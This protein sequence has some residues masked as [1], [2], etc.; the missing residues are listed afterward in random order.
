MS[1]RALTILCVL[2][3]PFFSG[4]EAYAAAR[5]GLKESIGRFTALER[6]SSTTERDE[7]AVRKNLLIAAADCSVSEAEAARETLKAFPASEMGF[8]PASE[9]L[10]ERLLETIAYAAE[11]KSRVNDVGIRGTK[12]I[13]RALKE[14]R[15]NVYLPAA[16]NVANLDLWK[17]TG[18]LVTVAERR[19]RQ[20]D[21]TLETLNLDDRRELAGYRD[22][23]GRQ[24]AS[25]KSALATARMK[26]Q[27]LDR[28]EEISVSIRIALD[29]LSKAYSQFFKISEEVN[30]VVPIGG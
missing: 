25:A 8:G 11:Q 2:V 15:L 7:L 30:K 14:W 19:E 13:A 22:E 23:A 28:A 26:L 27:A 21:A 12:D 17:K 6:A 20:I 24:L 4:G 1:R 3:V 16:G 9:R 18:D 10:A 5:C 29:G